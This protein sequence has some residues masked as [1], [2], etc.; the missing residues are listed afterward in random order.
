MIDKNSQVP[1]YVQLANIIIKK[2]KNGYFKPGDRINTVAELV[3]NYNVSRVTAVTA[4]EYLNKEGL[5]VSKRGKG[6]FVPF[7]KST[8]KIDK[9]RSL[10]EINEYGDSS[11]N[12]KVLF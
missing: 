11:M 1:M 2:I 4:L 8:E 3:E 5:I 9:L 6:S 7:K 12:Q 10:Q